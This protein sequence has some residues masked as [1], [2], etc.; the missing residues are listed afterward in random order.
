M[1]AGWQ[2]CITATEPGRSTNGAHDREHC[3]LHG[4]KILVAGMGGG[5][6]LGRYE[7]LL[8]SALERLAATGEVQLRCLSLWRGWHAS[9]LN[10]SA[11][12]QCGDAETVPRSQFALQTLWNAAA[13]RPDIV[14]F[15]IPNLAPLAL[16]LPVLRPSARIVVC[17]HGI[18]IWSEL[19][20]VRR[21]ALRRACRV[22]ASAT[23]NAERITA[24]QGVR[25][26]RIA[27]IH[28]A[29][30]PSWGTGGHF[31]AE[32][33]SSH[34]ARLLSVARLDADEGY[35]GVDAVIR[36]LCEIRRQ[37]PNVTYTVIGMGTDLPRLQ[38]LAEE[39]GVAEA[40]RFIGA[41]DHPNLLR[42][43]EQ[44]DVF[45]LPSTG[46]GFGLVF[47][48]AMSFAKP[49]VAVA[50]GGPIDIIQDGRTGRLVEAPD[51]IAGALLELLVNRRQAKEM[52]AR[53]RARLESAFSFDHY[54]R[55]W[56]ETL[57]SVLNQP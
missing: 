37:V 51:R 42:E 38:R 35:K 16:A 41:V 49:V 28:L 31:A 53:G 4:V 6:G 55:R 54:V 1:F 14:I 10:A 12:Y 46:E 11:A 7:A 18:E 40:V 29:L 47:L 24:V 52:G 8:L 15:T 27:L 48:E 56:R 26:E 21:V 44:C 19:P 22:V 20:W 50:A 32:A 9:Y 33:D 13:Y 5:F 43:Y 3:D 36:A 2:A 17:T 34:H 45:V 30:A 25:P 39:C 23:Y 57:D